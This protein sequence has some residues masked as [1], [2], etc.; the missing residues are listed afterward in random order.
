MAAGRGLRDAGRGTQA[1]GREPRD[2]GRGTRAAGRGT[3]AAGRGPRAA[4]HGTRAAGGRGT[5]AAGRGGARPRKN[6]TIMRKIWG[7]MAMAKAHDSKSMGRNVEQ[8]ILERFGIKRTFPVRNTY[9]AE[10]E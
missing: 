2:A 1:A 6:S 3:R 5:R 9:P 10:A 7:T 8:L 4:S